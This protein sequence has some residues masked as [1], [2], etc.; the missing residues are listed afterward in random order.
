MY[1][2]CGITRGG[3]GI[4]ISC[5]VIYVLQL[6]NDWGHID[7]VIQNWQGHLCF[8]VK[9]NVASPSSDAA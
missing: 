3:K 5:H 8:H 4:G 9:Q 6:R 2:F 1:L 7:H